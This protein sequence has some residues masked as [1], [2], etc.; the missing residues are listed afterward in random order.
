MTGSDFIALAE[1][2]A[3]S[4][5]EASFRSAA[6]RAYYGAFHLVRE[7]LENI[8][9][10]VPRNANAHVLLARQLQ[11]SGQSDAY[12]AGSLLGDLH[13]RRIKADYRLEDRRAGTLPFAQFCIDAAKE[14]ESAICVCQAEPA[15][16]EI[17]AKL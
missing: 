9:R 3:T 17:R 2:L 12:R 11:R 8:Q 16:S 13:S 6:S 14:I 4:Q 5:D 10:S 1:K 15:R 7:F